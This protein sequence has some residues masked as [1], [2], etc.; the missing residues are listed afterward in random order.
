[1]KKVGAL[2][3]AGL[4]MATASVPVGAATL[5]AVD[6]EEFEVRSG[7]GGASEVAEN[8]VGGTWKVDGNDAL[9]VEPNPA[10]D[11][12]LA[13][14]SYIGPVDDGL[15]PVP[16]GEYSFTTV[17]ELTDVGLVQSFAINW[18]ADNSLFDII[19][20]GVSLPGF[21]PSGI[22]NGTV[23]F[24]PPF[25]TFSYSVTDG[26]IW[27]SGENT[28]ELVLL[29]GFSNGNPSPAGISFQIFGSA[30]PE[31]AAWLLMIL[32]LGAVGFSMRRREGA[33]SRAQFA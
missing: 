23:E 12:P 11:D 2:I 4:A 32:G 7:N 9:E 16:S 25:Q 18:Y 10:W 15:D 5:V 27:T 8:G 22:E 19:V 17:L 24:N 31:P 29:N 13:G 26:S 20:N 3:A 33:V 1:M 28:I 6:A 21:A 14:T 30:V